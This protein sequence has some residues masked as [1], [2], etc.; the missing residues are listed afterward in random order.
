MKK[1]TAA[2]AIA[3]ALTSC[4]AGTASEATQT[5]ITSPGGYSVKLPATEVLS[6]ENVSVS[7]KVFAYTVYSMYSAFRDKLTESGMTAVDVGITEGE[8][9]ASQPCSLDS[10]FSSWLEMFSS[11]AE[12]SLTEQLVL[13][14]AA[15]EAGIELDEADTE[16][17]DAAVDAL[18]RSAEDAGMTL[19][20]FLTAR[21]GAG[22]TVSDVREALTLSLTA[23]KYLNL[24]ADG[25]D[26]SRNALENYYSAHESDIDTVDFLVYVFASGEDKYAQT[27]AGY[28]SSEDFVNYLEYYITTVRGLGE[29]DAR[30]ILT[31][32]T[33]QENVH[34]D[35]SDAV[36]AAFGLKSGES[37]TLDGDGGTKTVILVTRSCSRNKAKDSDGVPMWEAEVI[38]AIENE[39]LERVTRS[40]A[41]KYT[42]TRNSEKLLTVDITA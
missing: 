23:E 36:T 32:H 17:L 4:A 27:L 34:R 16:Q 42:V 9:L 12:Y 33:V 38:S 39:E 21:C 7:D 25:A 1:Y 18:T 6:T 28:S 20:A 24:A 5:P 19:G 2:L 35:D 8:S 31:E 26:T 40:A 14:E 22:V 15:K 29:D 10:S 30:E 41:S 13:A 3:L 37:I 11:Q